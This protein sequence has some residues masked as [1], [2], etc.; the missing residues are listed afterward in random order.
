M[1][2]R[3]VSASRLWGRV[4]DLVGEGWGDV[5]LRSLYPENL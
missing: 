2:E 1:V 3:G 5:C 4:W